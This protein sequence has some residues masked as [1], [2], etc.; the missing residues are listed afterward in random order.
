MEVNP[1]KYCDNRLRTA[2]AAAVLSFACAIPQL[3]MAQGTNSLPDGPVAC[4][5][6]QRVGN[7]SWTVLRPETL[8]P[9]G[10][11]LG[12]AAGQTFAPNQMYEG[13]EVTA[14]LDRNCGNR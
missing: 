12:L 3:A 7:G 5:A 8:Y 11:S 1:M 4:N 13:F 10:V 6:F 14:I 2:V 9:N